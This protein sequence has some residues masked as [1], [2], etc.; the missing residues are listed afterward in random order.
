LSLFNNKL[1]IV[2]SFVNII[3]FFCNVCGI[4]KYS[5]ST[6]YEVKRKGSGKKRCNNK[7]YSSCYD[8]S[9]NNFSNGWLY[10]IWTK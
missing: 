7:F 5:Q 2:L 8:L 9:N 6:G 4:H 10:L 1:L 3:S